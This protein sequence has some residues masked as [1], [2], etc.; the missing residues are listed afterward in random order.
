MI[1]ERAQARRGASVESVTNTS[2]GNNE[3]E[4]NIF[5]EWVLRD[6]FVA[7]RNPGYA[8]GPPMFKNR[9]PAKLEQV[10]WRII[11]EDTTRLFE[12]EKGGGI[13][14]GNPG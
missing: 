12:L 14:I 6:R 9:G 2:V 5:T 10:V 8:W 13:N 3:W 7:E 4:L 11:P 1:H